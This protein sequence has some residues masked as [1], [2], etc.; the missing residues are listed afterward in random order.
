MDTVYEAWVQRGATKT[1][2][3]VV[4]TDPK[5]GEQSV[6]KKPIEIPG[7]V[8]EAL[9]DEHQAPVQSSDKGYIEELA[10]RALADEDD[11]VLKAF[12]RETQTVSELLPQEQ[13]QT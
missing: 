7:G 1:T 8:E 6:E 4:V 9:V 2:E 12:I 11:N 3:N 13:P 5:T 10:K